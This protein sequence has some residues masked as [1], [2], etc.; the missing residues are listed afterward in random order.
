[1]QRNFATLV[2]AEQLD[3][4]LNSNLGSMLKAASE[5]NDQHVDVFVHGDSA[6]CDS[7]VAEVQKYPGIK[8][9]MVSKHDDLS[10]PYGDAL[11]HTLKALVQSKSYDKVIGPASAF[12]KDVVPR[13]GGLLDVQPITDVIQVLEG[14]AKF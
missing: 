10:K 4:H 1:M 8:S 13:L 12:G 6:S 5:L 2:V 3:G 11:S 9:I 14:G 7:Q